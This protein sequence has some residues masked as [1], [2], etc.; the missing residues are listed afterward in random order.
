MKVKCD[1]CGEFIK[2]KLKEKKHPKAVVETYFKCGICN[3]HFTCYFTD[4]I[5][6]NMQKQIRHL[7]KQNKIN[8][9]V[10][11]QEKIEQRMTELKQRIVSNG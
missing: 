10:A 6:R 2:I 9:V 11:L 3:Y 5:V 4:K 7:R 1:N 8:E